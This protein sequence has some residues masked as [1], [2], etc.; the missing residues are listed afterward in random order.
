MCVLTYHGLGCRQPPLPADVYDS[1]CDDDHA[2][3]SDD[4]ENH[5][6]FS[7]VAA[8]FSGP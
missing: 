5:K 4:D 1:R 8:C 3:G 6:Q 7:I 2:D